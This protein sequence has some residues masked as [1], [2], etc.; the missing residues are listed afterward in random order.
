MLESVFPR[1]VLEYVV[2]RHTQCSGNTSNAM[3]ATEMSALATQH[4]E[5]V[6]SNITHTPPPLASYC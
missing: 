4:D 3:C 6:N 5:A 2:T 1:H